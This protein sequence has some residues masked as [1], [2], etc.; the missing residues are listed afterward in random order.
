MKKILTIQYESNNVIQSFNVI[1]KDEWVNALVSKPEDKSIS[2][3][4]ERR[5][6]SFKKLEP[7]VVEG[8][9]IYESTNTGEIKLGFTPILTS[10]KRI[11]IS[12]YTIKTLNN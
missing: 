12:K 10:P 8:S 1:T 5:K 6:Q 2:D 7:Y 4:H 11:L 9:A 3:A